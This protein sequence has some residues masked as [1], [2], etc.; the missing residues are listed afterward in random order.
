MLL[1]EL[2][3]SAAETEDQGALRRMVGVIGEVGE[4]VAL[5][6]LKTAAGDIGGDLGGD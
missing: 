4:G 5:S 6:T 2:A 3:K 1:G